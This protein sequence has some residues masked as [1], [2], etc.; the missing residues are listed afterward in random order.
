MI[1]YKNRIPD[2]ES[3]FRLYNST[4]WN[5]SGRLSTDII[6]KGIMNSWYI[7][8][9]FDG[10]KLIGVGRI[11]S[12]GGYQVFI[13]DVIVLPEHRHKGIGRKIMEHLLAYCREHNVAWVQLSC[14]KGKKGFY[15][16]FGFEKRSADA[17]G[18][19]IFL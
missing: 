2:Q 4:G 3:F 18:M 14:A 10:T 11:V 1:E 13:T 15:E 19:Q 16:K 6:F 8:S 9:V 5:A 12:D 7:I 17:P